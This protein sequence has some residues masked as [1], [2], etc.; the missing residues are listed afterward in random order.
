MDKQEFIEQNRSRLTEK[1]DTA[2]CDT[3]DYLLSVDKT[4]YEVTGKYLFFSKDRDLLVKIAVEEIENGG[5]HEA[6][7]P[8]EG[9]AAGD[10]YVLCLYY[11]DDSRKRELAEKYRAMRGVAYR[12]W[13]SD[14]SSREGHFSQQFLGAI[15]SEDGEQRK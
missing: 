8:M 7:L 15:S 4:P 14:Q 10:D 9:F 5:F 1:V 2:P 6:K 11:K 12:Y 13:K 3:W